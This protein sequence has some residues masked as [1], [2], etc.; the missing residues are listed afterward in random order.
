MSNKHRQC[1]T[2]ITIIFK[3][4]HFKIDKKRLL[5]LFVLDLLSET[6]N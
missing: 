4:E 3:G 2:V 1:L 5:K 6:E